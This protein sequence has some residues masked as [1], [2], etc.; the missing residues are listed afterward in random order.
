MECGIL[1]INIIARGKLLNMIIINPQ[2]I[3]KK[4]SLKDREFIK[5]FT[6]FK[7]KKYLLLNNLT[8]IDQSD[9]QSEL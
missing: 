8:Q 5:I 6:S 7:L 4:I 1:T 3:D 2:I 9:L